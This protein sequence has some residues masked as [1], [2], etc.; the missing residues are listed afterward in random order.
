MAI[1][2]LNTTRP[3][4]GLADLADC[5]EALGLMAF[6]EEGQSSPTWVLLNNLNRQL[7]AYVD[8]ADEKGLL[9]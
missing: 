3:F 8:Q 9:T 1:D 7:R 2:D 4:D 6:N 5:Y